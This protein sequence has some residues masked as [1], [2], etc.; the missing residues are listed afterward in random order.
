[1]TQLI[2][3]CLVAPDA[4]VT[5]ALERIRTDSASER[6][7]AQLIAENNRI[8]A[9]KRRYACQDTGQAV[10]MVKL[11]DEAHR[12]RRIRRRTQIGSRP[13]HAHKHRG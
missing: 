7:A 6:T 10:I 9:E 2:S 5:R 1:M 11:G 3:D 4:A 13:A 12:P 8:A